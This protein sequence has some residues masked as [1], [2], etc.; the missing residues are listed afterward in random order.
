[1]LNYCFC[2][3]DA[4]ISQ[5]DVLFSNNKLLCFVNTI[6]WKSE[7]FYNENQRVYYNESDFELC[8][9]LI[10]EIFLQITIF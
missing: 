7:I 5:G 8:K 9:Y 4:E 6:D 3:Y 2:K 1:M 10:C